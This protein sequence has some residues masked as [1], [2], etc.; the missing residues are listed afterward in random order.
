VTLT[1]FEEGSV[2]FFPARA[3]RLGLVLLPRLLVDA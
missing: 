3:A 2:F 1:I